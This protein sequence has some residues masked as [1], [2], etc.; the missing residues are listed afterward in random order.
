VAI[1]CALAAF[2]ISAGA[3]SAQDLAG[4]ETRINTL[5]SSNQNQ[6]HVAVAADGSSMMVWHDNSSSGQNPIMG[7]RFAASGQQVEGNFVVGEPGRDP[8]VA[9]LAGGGWVVVWQ[10][11]SFSPTTP[12]ILA[13]RV[14][15]AGGLVGDPIEVDQTNSGSQSLPDVAGLTHA[16][17]KEEAEPFQWCLAGG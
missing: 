7:Q 15:S 1:R 17:C 11:Q 2:V 5:T 12:E 13:Q 10:R 6:P 8:H 9:A 16:A 3:A 4:D 14:S